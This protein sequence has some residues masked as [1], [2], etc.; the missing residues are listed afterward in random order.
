MAACCASSASP[1]SDQ[2]EWNSSIP[3]SYDVGFHCCSSSPFTIS[4]SQGPGEPP[5]SIPAPSLATA[6]RP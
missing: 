5:S 6:L 3:T 4:F 1:S 2:D